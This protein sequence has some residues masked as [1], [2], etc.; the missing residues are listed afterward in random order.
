[1]LLREMQRREAMLMHKLRS[2]NLLRLLPEL[3]VASMNAEHQNS[4]QMADSRKQG[5]DAFR[6]G[7]FEKAAALYSAAI[8]DSSAS[9]SDLAGL[10]LNRAAAHNALHR[11]DHALRD[12]ARAITLDDAHV[13]KAHARASLAL[14]ALGYVEAA[15][16]VLTAAPE[17]ADDSSAKAQHDATELLESLQATL[18]RLTHPVS[19]WCSMDVIRTVGFAAAEK[20][21]AALL[22][23]CLLAPFSELLSTALATALLTAQRPLA[24]RAVTAGIQRMR[25]T[26]AE[27]S[28]LEPLLLSASVTVEPPALPSLPVLTT[29]IGLAAGELDIT[30]LVDTARGDPDGTTRDGRGVVPLL[31]TLRHIAETRDRGNAAFK[32]GAYVDALALYGEALTISRDKL[33][34]APVLLLTNVAAT[35]AALTH[36][37]AA[38]DA[39]KSALSACRFNGKAWARLGNVLSASRPPHTDGALAAF[40][41][42]ALLSPEDDAVASK[43]AQAAMRAGEEAEEGLVLHPHSDA[44]AGRLLAA[45]YRPATAVMP[46]ARAMGA[47]PAGPRRVQVL[48]VFATW[49]GPCKTLAPK[50]VQ[51]AAG[52]PGATFIKI[53]GDACKSTAASLRVRAYPTIITLV[54]GKEQERMEGADPK[55]LAEMVTT[56]LAAARRAPIS[57]SAANAPLWLPALSGSAD[58]DAAVLRAVAD[59]SAAVSLPLV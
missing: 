17:A 51:Q 3:Q 59:A 55:R 39:C 35:E 29:Y 41:A 26:G 49:C 38:L 43:L 19:A 57:P 1:M 15:N 22:D 31:K 23:A 25:A 21:A 32:S 52:H 12:C 20:D 58:M 5:N 8:S 27:P 53:D 40:H 13:A 46:L 16:A 18:A 37:D 28:L 36:M 34:F 6:A 47:P 42:A 9:P 11:Y 2:D 33:L 10:L 7:Q 44:E 14:S 45:R 30:A 48:D 56:A 24:A 50:V 4:A 54:D